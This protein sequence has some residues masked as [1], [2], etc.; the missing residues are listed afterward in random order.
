MSLVI[1]LKL[2]MAFHKGQFLGSL[3]FN[4]YI[5]DIFFDIIE[6]DIASYADINTP[7]N[8]DFHPDNVISNFKKSASSLLNW[9]EESHM[10]TNADKCD[11][12]LIY[13]CYAIEIYILSNSFCQ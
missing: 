12:S 6:Y 3:L 11:L 7:Y 2:H 8:F 4:I 10:K 9:F 5:C 13:V 1:T